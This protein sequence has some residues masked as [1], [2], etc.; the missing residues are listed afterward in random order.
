[1]KKR[2]LS[3]ILAIGCLASAFSSCKGKNADDG[4]SSTE[5]VVQSDGLDG[6]GSKTEGDSS[7]T[8]QLWIKKVIP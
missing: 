2:I 6:N 4:T 3:I 5:S 8:K 1:M 7:D